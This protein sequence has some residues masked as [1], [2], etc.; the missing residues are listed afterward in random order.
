MITKQ[1]TWN[2]HVYECQWFKESPYWPALMGK[3]WLID[4]VS[5]VTFIQC[6]Q[7]TELAPFYIHS[8]CPMS[9]VLIFILQWW[10][11]S[12]SWN[13]MSLLKLLSAFGLQLSSQGYSS[14]PTNAEKA[15]FEFPSSLFSECTVF[16]FII[17]LPGESVFCLSV[18]YSCL[19]MN[20]IKWWILTYFF[21][22]DPLLYGHLM[23]KKFLNIPTFSHPYNIVLLFIMSAMMEKFP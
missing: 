21:P 10:E 20:V 16:V 5:N 15:E 12:C 19:I 11:F 18:C 14:R 1:I 6:R 4:C 9:L 2:I 8:L 7:I 3:V 23:K 17:H 13:F 22:G